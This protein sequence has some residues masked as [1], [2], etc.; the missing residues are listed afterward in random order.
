LKHVLAKTS[1]RR[2][3]RAA[4]KMRLAISMAQNGNADQLHEILKGESCDFGNAYRAI[5]NAYDRIAPSEETDPTLDY[6]GT[7][8]AF[9][10]RMV[11]DAETAA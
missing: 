5:S 2:P 9:L 1:N 6:L 3:K 11:I 10:R 4:E 8:M 7:A